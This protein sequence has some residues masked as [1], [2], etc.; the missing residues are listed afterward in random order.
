MP[1]CANF[2]PFWGDSLTRPMLITKIFSFN[3]RVT[4]SL[5]TRDTGDFFLILISTLQSNNQSLRC[6]KNATPLPQV[7][8]TIFQKLE[9]CKLK[10]LIH[11]LLVC[12]W[13]EMRLSK[14]QSLPSIIT[15][16]FQY[17]VVPHQLWA[18]S[19]ETTSHTQC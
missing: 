8:R 12:D 9:S 15:T 17:L 11:T 19:Y 3:L 14:V 4:G 13:N 18:T 5:V 10:A 1:I 16:F 7:A 2:G 6:I